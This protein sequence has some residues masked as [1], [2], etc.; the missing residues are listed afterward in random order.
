MKTP[1]APFT[2]AGLLRGHIYAVPMAM[3]VYALLAGLIWAIVY[4][5]WVV[6]VGG[7]ALLALLLRWQAWRVNRREHV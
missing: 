7:G 1:D 3:I 6:I 4:H 5:P 2:S